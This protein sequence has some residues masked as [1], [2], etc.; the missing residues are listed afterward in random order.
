MSGHAVCSAGVPCNIRGRGKTRFPRRRT[1]PDRGTGT[2]QEPH[3]LFYT[4]Q[5]VDWMGMPKPLKSIALAE[6]K[7]CVNVCQSMIHDSSCK[8]PFEDGFIV[9]L[10]WVAV[11]TRSLPKPHK[12]D[13]EK[14]PD[15]QCNARPC[16]PANKSKQ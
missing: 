11:N 7:N 14:F 15:V 2:M 1:A 16:L 5:T 6:G 13:G 3:S 4:I 12:P 10:E 8:R 9:L